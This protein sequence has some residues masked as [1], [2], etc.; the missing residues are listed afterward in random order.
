M[1]CGPTEKPCGVTAVIPTFQV[2]EQWVEPSGVDGVPNLVMG[3]CELLPPTEEDQGLE[4]L[5]SEPFLL[6]GEEPFEEEE[7]TMTSSS[8]TTKGVTVR[9]RTGFQ[10]ID[11]VSKKLIWAYEVWRCSACMLCRRCTLPPVC[12]ALPARGGR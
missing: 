12:C 4:D 7:Y 8:A 10:G 2:V 9:V 1:L 5:D 11:R 3:K 6:D